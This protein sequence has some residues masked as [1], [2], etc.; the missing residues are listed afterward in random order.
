M[1]ALDWFYCNETKYSVLKGCIGN[2][3]LLRSFMSSFGLCS[4]D[5]LLSVNGESMETVSHERAVCI[6]QNLPSDVE[7]IVSRMVEGNALLGKI[8][9]DKNDIFA[10]FA[11]FQ[12]NAS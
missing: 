7:I 6:L 11:S 5:R 2:V 10:F 4:G 1:S 12:I 3:K 8:V 9:Y